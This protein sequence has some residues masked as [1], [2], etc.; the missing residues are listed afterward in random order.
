MSQ[1]RNE[2]GDRAARRGAEFTPT[3][4][5]VLAAGG[6]VVLGGL[7]GC[8]AAPDRT[9]TDETDDMGTVTEVPGAGGDFYFEFSEADGTLAI[10]YLGGRYVPADQLEVQGE[11]IGGVSGVWSTLPGAEASATVDGEPALGSQDSVTLGAADG[12]GPV[13]S[14]YVVELVFVSTDGMRTTIASDR[15]P[16]A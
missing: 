1:N 16:D 15:G 8:S 9:E 6:S 12:Q 10:Y 7:A 2:T 13:E 11:N 14:N 5:A 4:R 3:R